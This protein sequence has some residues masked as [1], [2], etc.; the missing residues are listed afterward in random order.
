MTQAAASP[1]GR[2][3]RKKAVVLVGPKG[4]GKTTIGR[5]VE[6]ALGAR[7]IE[8]EAVAQRALAE[9]GG[10]INES[11]ARRAFEL[12]LEATDAVAREAPAIVLETTGASDETPRFLAAL[13]ERFNVVLVRV[14]ASRAVC[15]CRI[16]ARDQARQIQVSPDLIREMHAR[17]LA[18]SLPWDVEIDNDA[19]VGSSEVAHLLRPHL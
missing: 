18:L 13:H 7:F 2:S 5:M 8:V 9:A 16:Q 10:V 1:V 19:G 17:S 14:L 12:I 11:Y 3:V 15:E 6:A 4:S